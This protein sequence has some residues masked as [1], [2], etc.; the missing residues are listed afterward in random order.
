MEGEIVCQSHF[1]DIPHGLG[2]FYQDLICSAIAE[3]FAEISHG[4]LTRML[5]GTWS[6]QIL[7]E[8]ALRVLFREAI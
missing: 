6:G 3:V 4:R 2:I 1:G 5:N 7:L 8:G